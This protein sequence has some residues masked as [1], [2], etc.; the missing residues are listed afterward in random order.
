MVYHEAEI[1]EETGLYIRRQG[2]YIAGKP[3]IRTP[4]IKQM[5]KKL[6]GMG[7]L[8]TYEWAAEDVEVKKPYRDNIEHNL[9]I[10]ERMLGA[11]ATADVFI[12]IQDEDLHGALEERGA[13]ASNALLHPEGRKMYVL[14]DKLENERQ[15]IFDSFD[16][17]KVLKNPYLI[18]KDLG[19]IASLANLK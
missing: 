3:K 8:I 9:P 7:H 4:E 17:V 1:D 14:E 13:F 2:I 12:F 5:Y 16:F 15:S 10:A 19:R 11:A 6:K 18:Y